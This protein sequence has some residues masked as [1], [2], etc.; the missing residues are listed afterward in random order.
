MALRAATERP[1]MGGTD[2][3]AARRGAHTAR[4]C[5]R[6]RAGCR[7]RAASTRSKSKQVAQPSRYSSSSS[8]SSLLLPKPLQLPTREPPE[9]LPA[10]AHRGAHGGL[11]R[12]RCARRRAFDVVRHAQV[13]MLWRAH[14]TELD[15]RV[16][17]S[18]RARASAEGAAPSRPAAR[19]VPRASHPRSS[20]R[21]RGRRRE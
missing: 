5:S 13:A 11:R 12:S 2:S 17:S 14:L 6:A 3:T 7:R 18:D 21:G 16:R 8:C 10:K 4:L 1:V 15:A 19:L 20:L 9:S